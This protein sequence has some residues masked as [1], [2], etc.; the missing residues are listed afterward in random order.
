MVVTAAT[1]A[2]RDLAWLRRHMPQDAHVVATDVTS[3]EAVLCVM[4]PNS[5]ALLEAA[6]GA[7]LSN[8][9]HPFATWREVAIGHASVRAARITYVGELGWELYVATEFARGVFDALMEAGA[10]FGLKLA[11]LHALDSCRIEKAY[12]H[13]GHDIG[14]ED[15]PLEAGLMFAVKLDQAAT[16]SAATRCCAGATRASAGG[17]C[18]SC[19]TIPSRCCT[20]TSRSGVGDRLLGRTTSA[21]Y[22]H[23][24]GG[25]VA[26]GYVSDDI[27]PV[28]ELVG[29]AAFEIEIAGRRVPATA[30]LA[31]MYDPDNAAHPRMNHAP[32]ERTMSNRPSPTLCREPAGRPFAATGAVRVRGAFEHDIDRVFS[33]HWILAGH[34]SCAAAPGDWFV[35]EI[36]AESIIVVRGHDGALRAFANVCRHRGSR[37]CLEPAGHAR[38]CWSARTTPGPTIW[39]ARC[40]RR[41]RC[42][43]DFDK[44]RPRPE[45]GAHRASI[46]G[47]VFISLRRRRRC[48]SRPCVGSHRARR[49]RPYGWAT[50]K[51][52]HRRDLSAAGELEARRR[53]LPGM[54]PLHAVASGV[55]QAAR[56]GAAAR[57]DRRPERGD[58]GAH[59]RARH[60]RAGGGSPRCVRP[61]ARRRCSPSATRC[62]T[63]SR[64]AARTGRRSRR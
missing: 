1:A 37:I 57:A 30:S 16:S 43:R 63:A 13:W 44:A 27:G 32:R 49:M 5:R 8:A 22:G 33:R 11:G 50:A 39:T 53:E 41:G 56:A 7:D 29:Q 51:V 21:A 48:R 40:A 35:D 45:C 34:A 26:L 14:D 55:F 4:G 24:L 17:W 64:P 54:L 46:E 58:G 9:A 36:A 59:L 10:A 3:A 60:R 2:R 23:T 15:S 25:A 12:R 62:T 42:R 28:S 47:L 38:A 61:A 20:T 19:C 31:P 18:S 6:S 52:A